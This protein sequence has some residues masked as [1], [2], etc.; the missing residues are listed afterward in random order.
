MIGTDVALLQT[1]AATPLPTERKVNRLISEVDVAVIGAGAAGIAAARR[2]VEARTVSV[3]NLCLTSGLET[4]A[5]FA[6]SRR[7]VTTDAP[8]RGATARRT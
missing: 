6:I 1:R 5:D 8:G 3:L 4:V 2:L 7:L